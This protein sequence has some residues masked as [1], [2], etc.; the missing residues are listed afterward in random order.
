MT[1]D[2][3]ITQFVGDLNFE[4]LIIWADILKV[5]HNESQWLDDDFPDKTDE[6]RVA[7]AEAMGKMGK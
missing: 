2:T 5:P 6:L 7:V 1:L 4:V 3:L